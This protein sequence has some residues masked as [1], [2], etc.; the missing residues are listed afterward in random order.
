[1][2]TR[3]ITNHFLDVAVFLA[4]KVFHDERLVISNEYALQPTYVPEIGAV[5]GPVDYIT[6][7]AAGKLS[8]GTCPIFSC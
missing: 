5:A 6:S 7:P 4:R 3:K 1:M 8:M 2:G